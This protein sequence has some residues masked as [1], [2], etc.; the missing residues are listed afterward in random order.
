MA[1][2]KPKHL[3]Y[4]L[5]VIILIFLVATTGFMQYWFMDNKDVKL[6]TY[7][8]G[9]IPGAESKIYVGDS[10]ECWVLVHGYTLTP[11]EMTELAEQ[12]HQKYKDTVYIPRLDGHGQ[13][14]S[15]LEKYSI[16][17]WYNQVEQVALENN[18][19]YLV[20]SS[21][22]ASLVLRY[23]EENSP[24]KIVLLGT[25][26]KPEPDYL[27][28]TQLI[29]IL[30][31]IL[32]YTKKSEPGATILNIEARKDHISVYNFPLKPVAKLLKFNNLVIQD[33]DKIESEVLFIH[34][35]KDN[36]AN[37]E[38]AYET[39][40]LLNNKQEFI[41]LTNGGHVNLKDY[42]KQIVI[43]SI[44]DLRESKQQ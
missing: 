1:K 37:F 7:N 17:H 16:E 36:V 31:P 6:W 38:A 33:L 5:F 32:K 25:L 41:H 34:S 15:E 43:Q 9:I 10:D 39:Y 13:V 18:C 35:D 24:K 28:M 29:P 19:Q 2:L 27:P 40:Q 26:I 22:G 4:S 8:N 44:L 30:A 42:D 11:A 20:G 23:A 14:P 21:M 12:I 3:L